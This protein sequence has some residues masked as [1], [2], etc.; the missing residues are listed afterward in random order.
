MAIKNRTILKTFFETGDIPTEGQYIHLIDSKVN[1]G[2]NNVG[3]IQLTGNI[4]ASGNISA[5]GNLSA[6]GD[7][8]IDGKSHFAGPITASSDISSSEAVFA[9]S[10]IPSNGGLITSDSNYGGSDNFFFS[11]GIN[12]SG[13]ITASGNISASGTSHILGGDLTIGDDFTFGIH[14]MSTHPSGLF[15]LGSG[16]TPILN[17]QGIH[18]T[19]SGNISASIVATG[20]FGKLEASN[21]KLG[22]TEIVSTATEINHL[23]GVLSPVKEAYDTI[24]STQQGILTCTE[25]DNGIDNVI[26]ANLTT[27]S[28]ATFGGLTIKNQQNISVAVGGSAVADG[29]KFTVEVNSIPTLQAAVSG[30]IAMTD[31]IVRLNAP[32]ISSTND[33]VKCTHRGSSVEKL[34]AFVHHSAPEFIEL[35]IANTHSQ[36]FTGST[37][38]FNCV[39]I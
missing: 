36:P 17:A 20:S 5:S 1:L 27:G 35:R 39:A 4:T 32:L 10:F 37:A 7:L 28:L 12:T 34:E 33:V 23:D 2:E 8:D 30:K 3:N 31:D 14:S 29:R 6:T 15:S 11:R 25:L 38:T 16:S 9:S 26:L 18:L 22:G 24:A 13:N 19:A 21:L